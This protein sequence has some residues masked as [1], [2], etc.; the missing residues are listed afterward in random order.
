MIYISGLNSV[1]RAGDTA[2]KERDTICA[3]TL[4]T[5]QWKLGALSIEVELTQTTIVL[6]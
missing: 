5:F 3:F 2:G 6:D 1:V 4:L